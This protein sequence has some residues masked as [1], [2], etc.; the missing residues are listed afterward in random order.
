MMKLSQG[1]HGGI[2]PVVINRFDAAPELGIFAA[3][4]EDSSLIS[5]TML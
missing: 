4:G 2:H 3:G 1:R 5:K